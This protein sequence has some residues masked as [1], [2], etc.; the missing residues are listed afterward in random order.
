MMKGE[1]CDCCTDNTFFSF[2]Y[3]FETAKMKLEK[4]KILIRR[5]KNGEFCKPKFVS[6]KDDS[7]KAP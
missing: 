1:K 2:F 7:G 3:F 4:N 6:Q 5:H